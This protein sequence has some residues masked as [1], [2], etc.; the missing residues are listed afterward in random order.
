MPSSLCIK[1]LKIAHVPH[2]GIQKMFQFLSEKY[3]WKGIYAD[4]VNFVQ[5]CGPCITSKHHRIPQAPFQ[6]NPLPQH[7][8]EFVLKNLVGPFKS[9]FNNHSQIFKISSTLS[10]KNHI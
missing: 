9:H 10:Y 3:Y 2:Y 5:F 8:G 4:T 6:N 1:A 7:P